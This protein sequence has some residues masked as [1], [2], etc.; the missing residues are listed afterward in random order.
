MRLYSLILI[1]AA[2]G[3]AAAAKDSRGKKRTRKL[4]G[5][6]G[7]R[8]G[9]NRAG[10]HGKGKGKGN[11][12]P[13]A[14]FIPYQQNPNQNPNPNPNLAPY[15]QNAYPQLGPYQQ[16]FNNNVIQYQQESFDYDPPPNG[17]GH[18]DFAR[19]IDP[20]GRDANRNEQSRKK[21]MP[22]S[23]YNPDGTFKTTTTTNGW[24]APTTTTT[25]WTAPTTPTTSWTAP[26]PGPVPTPS[27]GWNAGWVPSAWTPVSSPLPASPD[28]NNQ[29]DYNQLGYKLDELQQY[30]PSNP[31]DTA[32]PGTTP[33]ATAY[34]AS[35]PFDATKPATTPF[36]TAK[37][38]MCNR[39]VFTG[40]FTPGIFH[41]AML[42]ETDEVH[43]YIN[44]EYFPIGLNIN[45]G[46]RVF[47]YGTTNQEKVD[48]N[49]FG[50]KDAADFP[51]SV[52][53]VFYIDHI[54]GVGPNQLQLLE[55]TNL[56]N[57]RVFLEVF[58]AGEDDVF[59]EV[60]FSYP[61]ACESYTAFE[62]FGDGDVKRIL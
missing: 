40:T 15:Q 43:Q 17:L 59:Y 47:P 2:V 50:I 60:T 6:K 28:A 61:N 22:A 38:A 10:G 11:S 49:F 25:S 9:M 45:I 1:A 54:K 12:N 8:G 62:F 3:C 58:N 51:P 13:N 42:G 56:Q 34:P 55:I 52:N 36:A 32:R 24:T 20:S 26:A 16:N 44:D 27:T 23:Y 46:I 39:Q 57:S 21:S 53:D 14:V 18:Q 37:P 19:D 30:P 41:Q 35:N 4:K 5:N 31:F 48:F 7:A 29:L 33:F